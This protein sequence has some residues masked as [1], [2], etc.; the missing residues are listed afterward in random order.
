MIG[1]LVTFSAA[2]LDMAG[3]CSCNKEVLHRVSEERN[4]LHSVSRRCAGV[5]V[6]GGGP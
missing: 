6:H 3:G 1:F 5:P 2:Y 4:K